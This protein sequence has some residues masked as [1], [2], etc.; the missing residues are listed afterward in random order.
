MP[1]LLLNNV[2]VGEI[3]KL[4]MSTVPDGFLPCDGSAVS[5]TTYADLFATIGIT[6]GPGDGSTTFNVPDGQRRTMVGS[7]GSGTGTLGNTVGS[8]GG[9]ETH[10]LLEAELALH[11]HFLTSNAAVNSVPTPTT[12]MA[13]NQAFGQIQNNNT[14]AALTLSS[15]Q[16]GGTGDTPHNNM[17]PS[18][19]V[20]FVIRY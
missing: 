4:G 3:K 14:T 19:V 18:M 2:P 1:R 17:Q 15:I 8:T 7:G 9:E 11:K 10:Q 13:V 20:N 6:W 16:T 12:Q 5:R